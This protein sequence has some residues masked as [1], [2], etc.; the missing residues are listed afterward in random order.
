MFLSTNIGMRVRRQ[1]AVNS[2]TYTLTGGA[3]CDA[4]STFYILPPANLINFVRN[5]QYLARISL[6]R[7]PTSAV[8]RKPCLSSGDCL[9]GSA[10]TVQ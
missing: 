5:V 7:E 1:G 4:C 3:M 6:V 8:G 2:G 10:S 9:N